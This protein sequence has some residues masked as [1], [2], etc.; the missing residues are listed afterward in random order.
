L[1]TVRIKE[2]KNETYEEQMKSHKWWVANKE[3][4]RQRIIEEFNLPKD[5]KL[6]S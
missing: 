1:D 2:I 4:I 5:Y 3:S 6:G